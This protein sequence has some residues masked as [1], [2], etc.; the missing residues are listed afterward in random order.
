MSSSRMEEFLRAKTNQV[1]SISEAPGTLHLKTDGIPIHNASSPIRYNL[2]ERQFMLS[3]NKDSSAFS[4]PEL[5]IHYLISYNLSIIARYETEWWAELLKTMP[6]D[7]YPCIVQ[8]LKISQAKVPFLI[9]E[10][11]KSERF[12]F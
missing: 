8:F 7:D 12:H 6:N 4:L 1:Y 10:W 3:L 9:F 11:I 5:L 2:E